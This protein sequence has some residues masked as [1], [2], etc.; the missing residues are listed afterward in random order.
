MGGH[1][2]PATK[3]EYHK[4]D[5]TGFEHDVNKIQKDTDK[6]RTQ[7]DLNLIK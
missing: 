5:P 6:N 1:V 4:N 7:M 2:P 3:S